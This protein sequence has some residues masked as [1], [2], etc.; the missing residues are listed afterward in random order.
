MYQ[1]TNFMYVL[2]GHG[3]K[4]SGLLLVRHKRTNTT[5][6]TPT[7]AHQKGKRKNKSKHRGKQKESEK[8]KAKP[9]QAKGKRKQQN[10]Y[11]IKIARM[12]YGLFLQLFLP[13]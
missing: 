9:G 2:H 4:P 10:K 1:L 7:K 8:T 11:V 5:Q 13:L 12:Q 3:R 6:Q